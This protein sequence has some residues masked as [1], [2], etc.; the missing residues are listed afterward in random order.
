MTRDASI[1]K[2]DFGLDTRSMEEFAH[3]LMETGWLETMEADLASMNHEKLGRPFTFTDRAIQWANRLR[4][5]FKTSYRLARGLMNHFLRGLGFQGISLTQ[6]YDRCRRA[7]A[8]GGADGRVLASGPCDVDV[9]EAPIS[10]AVD[11]TGMSLNK[12]GGWRCYHWNLK[13]VTGWIKLH[14]AADTDTNRILAY[15]VTDERCGDVNLLGPLVEDV[16][17]AGHKV[18][19]ILA[20]AAYD[21]KAYWNEYAARGIDVAINIRNSQLNK[22]VPDFPGRIRSHGCAAR[23]REMA[24]I[25]KIG[26][27]EWKKEKGYGRRWK[28]ECTFSDAKRLFGDILRSRTRQ[29]DVEETVAKVLLLNEYKGIRMRCQESR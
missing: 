2:R 28:V 10:V 22:N 13:S 29:T 15:A 17:S 1:G 12:Y 18:G 11:S 27:D 8:V 7:S 19:K 24:R 5:V 14:A 4:I 16:I 3:F 26:R 6:F 23:G 25:L 9:S 21:K 20:D